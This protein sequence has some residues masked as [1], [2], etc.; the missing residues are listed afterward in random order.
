M[1]VQ[2]R[3]AVFVSVVGEGDIAVIRLI[4]QA[5]LLQS[6]DRLVDRRLGDA[7]LR[8][9]VDRADGHIGP[10]SQHDDSLQIVLVRFGHLLQGDHPLSPTRET[11]LVYAYFSSYHTR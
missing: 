7:H 3:L 2:D 8:G 1:A 10:A 6:V 11:P 4:D 9:D 5:L